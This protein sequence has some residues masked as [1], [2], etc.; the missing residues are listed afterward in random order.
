MIITE[1]TKD[2]FTQ[3]E[4][5]A[6]LRARKKAK[7]K[8]FYAGLDEFTAHKMGVVAE[9]AFEK[10]TGLR[11]DMDN[12]PGGDGGIDFER[13][14]K[15]IQLKTRNSYTNKRPD[16]AVRKSHANADTYILSSWHELHPRKVAFIGCI[17]DFN[18]KQ[19]D[20][21]FCKEPSWYVARDRLAP[22]EWLLEAWGMEISK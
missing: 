18:L 22:I 7:S 6:G 15:T 4:T 21:Q 11:A 20:C 3:A 1:L 17:N 16:L 5:V 14:G 2:E 19:F 12:L 13:D 10:L 9:M 8:K